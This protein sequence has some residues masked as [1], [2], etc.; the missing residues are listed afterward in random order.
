MTACLIRTGDEG[1]NAR[2]K[3][4]IRSLKMK[5]RRRLKPPALWASPGQ[6]ALLK[7]FTAR[8]GPTSRGEH[9][10]VMVILAACRSCVCLKA[11]VL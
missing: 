4:E 2:D 10:V 1:M 6:S 3:E 7:P 11:L 5:T 8:S 9:D